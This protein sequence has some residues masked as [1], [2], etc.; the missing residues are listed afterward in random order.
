M[1]ISPIFNSILRKL[2]T[3]EAEIMVEEQYQISYTEH[4]KYSI[5]TLTIADLAQQYLNSAKETMKP[6]TYALYE[7]YALNE[8]APKIG[9]MDAAG[10]NRNHL[11]D[12]LEQCLYSRDGKIRRS[13]N[14]M[15]TIEAV[16]RAIF[17]YG[18]KKSLI[19][20]IPLGKIKYNRQHTENDVFILSKWEIQ[21]LLHDARQLGLAQELQVMLPL[22]LGL[23]LSELCGLKWE[24][25]NLED[26]SIFVHRCL[27]RIMQTEPDG[28]SATSI[29]VYELD[30]CEQRTFR[31][32]EHICKL[33]EKAFYGEYKQKYTHQQLHQEKSW[34]VASLDYKYVEGRTLQ[35]RLKN[36]GSR[37]GIENLS[38]RCLRDTFAV[39]SLRAGANA[40]TLANVLGV[41]MQVVCDRYAEWMEYDD[42]FLE[43]LE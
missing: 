6:S 40:M 27:K 20:A 37:G 16:L 33:L 5:S 11:E 43:R 38:Y 8:V 34:F 17:H 32:P 19:P 7:N 9:W 35:Y 29:T 23:G 26:K 25:I 10:F 12:F 14:T 13:R 22:Y 4:P 15:Y 28:S 39:A 42:G 2:W 41:K 1:H 3:R 36:L 18:I 24:D 31:I 21:G 30:P